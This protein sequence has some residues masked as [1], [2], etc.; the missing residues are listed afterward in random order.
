MLV[1]AVRHLLCRKRQHGT[2]LAGPQIKSADRGDKK[3]P[4]ELLNGT[5]YNG[6]ARQAAVRF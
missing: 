4:E 1:A 5:L 6:G 2:H 3:A